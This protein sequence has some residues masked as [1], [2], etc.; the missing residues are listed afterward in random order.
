LR[1]ED[2]FPYVGLL[3]VFDFLGCAADDT[4]VVLA[5]FHDPVSGVTDHGRAAF[6][7]GVPSGVMDRDDGTPVAFS[8]AVYDADVFRHVLRAVLIQTRGAAR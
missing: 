2:C 5:D 3:V 4:L 8:E 7:T 6:V 1:Y